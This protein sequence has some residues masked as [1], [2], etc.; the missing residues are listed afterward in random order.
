MRQ[1]QAPAEPPLSLPVLTIGGQRHLSEGEVTLFG[2]E[3]ES[4][5]RSLL[6]WYT[7]VGRDL[8]WRRCRD[9]YAIWVS[10]IMLQQT[11]V[12]TVIPY[13]HRWLAQFP[14]IEQL[15][16]AELQQVLKAWEGLGYYTRARNLHRAAQEIMQH[17]SGV[18]PTA[19][20]D[21]L[22]LP[23]IGRTTAGGI[24]SAAFDQPVA[25]LDGNVKRVL[26]RLVALPVPLTKATKQ[27][28]Q[29]SEALLDREHPRDFNQALM[30]LGATVCTPKKPDCNSCPWRTHCQAYNLG[31][32]SHLPMREPSSPLP[33]KNIGVAVIWNE[34]G[35]ILID[36]RRPN[37]LLGGLWEFPGGKIELGETVEECIKREIQE[38]LAI[39]I[40]VG[41]RL[42]TIDHAYSH[43]RVTLNV[44]HCRHLIGVPQPL[45]C[46]EIRWVT[47]DEIDQFPFPK[48]NAQII[49]ALRQNS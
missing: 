32:Q 21:V 11:Q 3:G 28:W 47:L 19:L 29:F 40:E 37:G 36:R 18:F 8:P 26:A 23:G 42:I 12:K 45:E 4:L 20:N 14:T 39:E 25:I 38:E 15:A 30:D 48:A 27:L 34:Q 35:Q 1:H 31:I 41:D 22:A 49:A 13:Y 2:K 10:E 33:H 7:D 17:H 43:F 24:L 44:H 9:P 5:K 6:V 16:S 46:D